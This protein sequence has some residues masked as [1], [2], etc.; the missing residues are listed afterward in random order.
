VSLVFA[1]AVLDQYFAR[2]QPYQFVWA[3]GLLM[4]CVSTAAEFWTEAW[5]MN[6]T[7]YRLWYFFGAICVAA[8]LGMGTVYLLAR[9]RVAHIVM[10]VLAAATV[11]A[12]VAVFTAPVDISGLTAMSGEAMPRY[13]RLSTPFFNGFGTVALVGGALYSGWSFWRRRVMRHRVLSNALI[14]V[15]AVLPALGGTW[16]R[17]EGSFQ[18]LYILELAGIV[19]IFLGFLRNREVF[20]LSRFPLVH[21]FKRN[22]DA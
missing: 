18:P 16:I 1:L 5:G 15:G 20:G 10:G 17:V 6:L 12:A 9:R 8:Y 13:V 21:G 19:I 7:D 22:T 14:A 4:Y 3:I 11:Y 2:R